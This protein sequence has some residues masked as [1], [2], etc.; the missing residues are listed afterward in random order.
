MTTVDALREARAGLEEQRY[1]VALSHLLD[2]WRSRRDPRVAGLIDAVDDLCPK[3][4][5]RS[6]WPTTWP[7]TW[8]G[9]A[10]R[11]RGLLE[12]PLDPR[13]GKRF[14][15]EVAQ[16]RYA[17]GSAARL[18]RP[19]LDAIGRIGDTRCREVLASMPRETL[20]KPYVTAI[21]ASLKRAEHVLSTIPFQPAESAEL[22]EI[23]VIEQ[24]LCVHGAARVNIQRDSRELLD[25]IHDD[26]EDDERR[27]LYADHLLGQGDPLGELV[28]I[29]L[30]EGSISGPEAS[31][32]QAQK[33][34]LLEKY[35]RVWAGELGPYF[36]RQLVFERGLFAGGL[37]H[38]ALPPPALRSSREWRA[39]R[40]VDLGASADA[41][42]DLLAL[43]LHTLLGLPARAIASL[44]ESACARSLVELGLRD[45]R[46][47]PEL[48]L[49]R[50]GQG[51]ALPRLRKLHLASEF[52]GHLRGSELLTRIEEVVTDLVSP[53][54]DLPRSEAPA[55]ELVHIWLAPSYQRASW[56]F[57]VRLLPDGGG[58]VEARVD[59]KAPPRLDALEGLS[60]FIWTLPP[61]FLKR[62]TIED[63]PRLLGL[64][65][66][67][68]ARLNAALA[69][70]S[71]LV[72]VSSPWP[73]VT[74]HARPELTRRRALSIELLGPSLL[75]A[76]RLPIALEALWALDPS[77][78]QLALPNGQLS[79]LGGDPLATCSLAAKSAGWLTLLR[80][81]F[82]GPSF[83]LSRERYTTTPESRS[84][85]ILAVDTDQDLLRVRD[86]LFDWAE[87]LEIHHAQIGPSEQDTERRTHHHETVIRVYGDGLAIGA[88]KLFI[89]DHLAPFLDDAELP[90]AYA[91]TRRGR[92][93][94]LDRG[95]LHAT[96]GEEARE[97]SAAAF[98]S[99]LPS[100]FARKWGYRPDE[101]LSQ[102]VT[103]VLAHRGL[104]ERS[105]QT[106][107]DEWLERLG[108][109]VCVTL[110]IHDPLL[111]PTLSAV[112]ECRI[113]AG[114]SEPLHPRGAPP[115]FA[116]GSRREA[117][118]GL[119]TIAR[120]A[121]LA[122]PRIERSWAF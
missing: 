61:S 28:M 93:L 118:E 90:S 66:H 65:F 57:H 1:E 9:A 69:T 50:L 2:A 46:D 121:D 6:A 70:A 17:L 26:P 48:E 19:M 59:P 68:R 91:A 21:R 119:R 34:A 63:S 10:A 60:A 11:L 4:K 104:V 22:R 98:R 94:F 45:L 7:H 78:R 96:I 102:I 87:R 84:R 51:E 76:R 97:R 13:L 58:A 14:A 53:W 75:D 47:V 86:W 101:V 109:D 23:E 67:E 110:R 115:T 3:D 27:A 36:E 99:A 24:L 105:A 111:A 12:W 35:G 18:Y 73:D 32:I 42:A 29:Q 117:E 107:T 88:P 44:L 39:L 16:P 82:D 79:E 8:Q 15:H 43:D 85:L 20:P 52:L 55:L 74:A 108:E 25:A 77:A 5:L 81:E 122:Y 62:L 33:A 103:P 64:P 114:A 100:V 40:Y 49:I 37:V 120:L 106:I 54:A 72:E 30:R 112:L 38:Q 31:A 113:G 56:S 41:P 116:A 71:G 92:L 89:G 83:I 80:D 95:G